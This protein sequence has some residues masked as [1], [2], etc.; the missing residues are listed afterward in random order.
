MGFAL[1]WSVAPSLNIPTNPQPMVGTLVKSSHLPFTS[2]IPLCTTPPNLPPTHLVWACSWPPFS[3]P[4]GLAPGRPAVYLAV[5][6]PWCT[7]L[8]SM[9]H[10]CRLHAWGQHAVWDRAPCPRLQPAREGARLVASGTAGLAERGGCWSREIRLLVQRGP[11]A[12]WEME[13]KRL[14][15]QGNKFG[16]TSPSI[17]SP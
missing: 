13:W 3:L 2:R 12:W 7:T 6:W 1:S 10:R 5:V 16:H 14:P 8:V 17:T 9:D 15:F 4:C 11:W